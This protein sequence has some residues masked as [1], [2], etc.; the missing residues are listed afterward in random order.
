MTT[1]FRAEVIGSMVRPAYLNQAREAFRA[2]TMSLEQFK[3]CENRAV[4]EV[5]AIQERAGVDVVTDG[6][7]RRI[8]YMS[9]MSGELRGERGAVL[10]RELRW[11]RRV[12]DVI[13]E[14][15]SSVPS[16]PITRKLAFTHSTGAEEF[17]YASGKT[18]KPLKVTMP[19]PTAYL[20]RW[21]P[22]LSAEA[23]PDP[24]KLLADATDLIR[25]EIKALAAAGCKYV[26][27]DAPELT[28]LAD[29]LRQSDMARL[30]PD[31]P[32]WMSNEGVD[33]INAVATVPGVTFGLHMCRGNY[34]G[35]WLSEAPW[36]ALSR[37]VFIRTGNF[38]IF[39]L[40][41]DD[42]RSGSFEPLRD[43][44]DD[45]VAVL[46]LISTKRPDLE[47]AAEIFA[48]ID[49]ASG[50]FPREQLALSTQCGFS[51]DAHSN[52]LSQE[53]EEAKLKLV[54]QIAHQVWR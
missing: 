12:G 8:I 47:P 32:R 41:Y 22:E 2:G 11:R 40:E 19:G 23:Y 46:G 42:W 38:N 53:G 5:L 30:H 9:P 43:L 16:V 10:S 51:P 1:I 49:E 3:E 54:A 52:V 28:S 45:K 24:L 6:E 14:R 18:T 21:S 34:K 27:I 36:E 7:M 25:E 20:N 31:F 44:K 26:Q 48:R 39:L 50:Y 37:H 17:R 4:D 15:P 29:D 13:E 33:A 35:Y